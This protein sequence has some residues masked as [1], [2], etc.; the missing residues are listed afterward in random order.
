V[1]RESVEI[2]KLS[3]VIEWLARNT[4]RARPHGAERLPGI[5]SAGQFKSNGTVAGLSIGKSGWMMPAE[6]AEDFVACLICV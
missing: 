6:R 3:S 5:F 2:P 4:A 1:D